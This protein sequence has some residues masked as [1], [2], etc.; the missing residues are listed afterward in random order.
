M[1][2]NNFARVLIDQGALEA[3]LE[4]ARRAVALI[5]DFAGTHANCAGALLGLKR[6]AEAETALRRVL[7]LAPDLASLRLDLGRA[8]EGQKPVRGSGRL[9]P[10]GD[11]A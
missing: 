11:R 4:S 2:H 1:A 5:P 3:G 8:L 7:E 6:F 10:A 9:V